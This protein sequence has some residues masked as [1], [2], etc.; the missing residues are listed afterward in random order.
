M[1]APEKQ[2]MPDV[3]KVLRMPEVG[4]VLVHRLSGDPVYVLALESPELEEE[5]IWCQ[6][7]NSPYVVVGRIAHS[8]REGH[9]IYSIERFLPEELQTP[10][11]HIRAKRAE[12]IN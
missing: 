5:K 2:Q 7:A 12:S 11:I 9:T 10:E 4:D 1:A 6:Q 3:V 8:M